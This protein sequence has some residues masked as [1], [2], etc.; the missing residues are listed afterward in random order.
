MTRL[1]HLAA[2]IAVLVAASVA[3]QEPKQRMGDDTKRAD[4]GSEVFGGADASKAQTQKESERGA[5]SRSYSAG[6]ADPRKM[7]TSPRGGA[8]VGGP[9][10]GGGG[11]RF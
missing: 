10:G 3:A 11:S 9:R 5:V 2:L 6:G 7:P 8:I 4:T 1:P